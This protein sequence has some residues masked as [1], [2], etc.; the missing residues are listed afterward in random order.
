M[1]KLKDNAFNNNTVK[2]RYGL[3]QSYSVSQQSWSQPAQKFARQSLLYGDTVTRTNANA[4][5]KLGKVGSTTFENYWTSTT[6]TISETWAVDTGVDT[7]TSDD[8][9]IIKFGDPHRSAMVWGIQ[10]LK[11][12]F[13]AAHP[14][15]ITISVGYNYFKDVARGTYTATDVRDPTGITNGHYDI[16]IKPEDL[17]D[18][19]L[20]FLDDPDSLPLIFVASEV[21]LKINGGLLNL[22]LIGTYLDYAV[23]SDGKHN[24]GKADNYY[25]A[26]ISRYWVEGII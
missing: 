11:E 12:Q 3:P 5:I 22:D 4:G 2:C 23:A 18:N 17:D 9:I 24:N 21:Y 19:G 15:G 14:S 26:V 20:F 8:I 16:E 7:G 10:F 6:H 25:S 13:S 1:Y